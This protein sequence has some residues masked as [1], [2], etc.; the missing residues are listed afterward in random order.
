MVDLDCSFSLVNSFW[1]NLT[2]I[3]PFSVFLITIPSAPATTSVTAFGFGEGY[4]YVLT[5]DED[6][7]P[8]DRV[9][10]RFLYIFV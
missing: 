3:K 2:F 7:L 5:L 10:Y 6:Q 1:S 4:C 9:L 8:L